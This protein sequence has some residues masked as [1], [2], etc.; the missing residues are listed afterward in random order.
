MGFFIG[1][2]PVGIAIHFPV[3]ARAARAVIHC[4]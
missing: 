1:D 4:V 2:R 3:P